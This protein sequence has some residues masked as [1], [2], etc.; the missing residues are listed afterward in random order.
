MGI[1]TLKG[2]EGSGRVGEV[3]IMQGC[4]GERGQLSHEWGMLSCLRILEGSGEPHPQGGRPVRMILVA[5]PDLASRHGI[6]SGN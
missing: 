4:H 1:L 3:V 2:G 5:D 6:V